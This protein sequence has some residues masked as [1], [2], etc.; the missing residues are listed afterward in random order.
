MLSTALTPALAQD[1]ATGEA[2]DAVGTVTFMRLFLSALSENVGVA[3]ILTAA[4]SLGVT[5]FGVLMAI[6]YLRSRRAARAAADQSEAELAE[7]RGNLDMAEAL[8][9]AEDT[10][11]VSWAA[12]GRAQLTGTLP[13]V[14]HSPRDCARLV[15]FDDWLHEDAAQEL[16][17]RLDRLKGEGEP[18]NVTVETREGRPIEADGRIRNGKAI[19]RLRAA[20]G[21]RARLGRLMA[22][23]DGMA[24]ET[25]AL[26]ELL[27]KAGLPIWRHGPQEQTVWANEPFTALVAP[28]NENGKPAPLP[29]WSRLDRSRGARTPARINLRVESTDRKFDVFHMPLGAGAMGVAV[30][31][32]ESAEPAK[33]RPLP[34]HLGVLDRLSAAVAIFDPSQRLMFA[35]GAFQNLFRLDPTW[36]Q[37]GVAHGELLDVLREGQNLPDEPDYRSWKA[38]LL[39]RYAAQHAETE[40]WHLADGRILDVTMEPGQKG[41]LTC[42]FQDVTEQLSLESRLNAMMG[43]QRE[44]LES[45]R[46]GVAVFGSDGRLTFSNPAFRSTWNLPADKLRT[47]PHIETVADWCQ[48]LY[49]D[50]E[51][52]TALRHAVTDVRERRPSLSDRM[53]LSDARTLDYATVP[54][55]DGAT[56]ITFAD[57]THQIASEKALRQR[58]EA[59]EAAARL[60]NDFIQHVSYELRTPLTSVIGFA[61]LLAEPQTGPLAEKQSNYVGHILASSETLLSII[62]NILDLA[63]IDAG[64]ME[65]HHEDVDPRAVAAQVETDMQPLLSEADVT[66]ETAIPTEIGMFE[67]DPDRVRQVLYNLVSN[68]IGFSAPGQTVRLQ[69]DRLP[70]AMRFRVADRGQGIDPGHLDRIF[71]RFVTRAAGTT[72]RGAGLGLSIVKSFVDLHGGTIEVS[73]DLGEGTT[74]TVAFPLLRDGPVA[75]ERTAGEGPETVQSASSDDADD[76]PRTLADP[77]MAGRETS[78]ADRSG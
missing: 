38:R 68:A 78:D 40:T 62:N 14:A 18:F 74:I 32:A 8:L 5:V 72:H 59:L 35:N 60:K 52:W 56:L 2:G 47:G 64:V 76:E 17:L 51:T 41:G 67:A 10:A 34:S 42:L 21:E 30:P 7:L 22:E 54:L 53:E 19:L 70:N 20:L 36:T 66:L 50:D 26:K 16:R 28:P 23:R 13:G 25:R 31:T 55:L 75:L 24:E 57:I 48:A 27:E 39:E 71:D 58:N 61:E 12:N 33:P 3:Q 1:A 29:G 77:E 15:A 63:T 43:V 45:M 11:V 73:S 49:S 44:T 9:G 69:C 6:L 46:E 65:L 37:P 4:I